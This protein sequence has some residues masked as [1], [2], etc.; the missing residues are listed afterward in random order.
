MSAA[1]RA[2]AASPWLIAA[3]LLCASSATAE[4]P[5]FKIIAHVQ[6]KGTV[7]HREQVA[8]IFL[9]RANRWGDG[10]AVVPVDQSWRSPV[11]SSF[12]AAVLGMPMSQVQDYWRRQLSDHHEFSPVVR[13]SDKEVV[14]LVAATPGG[15][16]YVSLET[17]T[18]EGVKVL[19]LL[20]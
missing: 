1:S 11:R 9:K 17:E 20:D 8:A 6:T 10:L 2:I 13:G 16:G 7:I 5:A 18:G 14:D 19:K 4:E 12:S 15:I 3:G